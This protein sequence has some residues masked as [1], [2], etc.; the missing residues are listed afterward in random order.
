[1]PIHPLERPRPPA[2]PLAGVGVVVTRPQRQAA[3][4][5]QKLAALGATP[6]VWPAIVILPPADRAAL[7][8]AHAALADYDI[9]VFV[10]ANATEFGAPDP[11]RWPPALTVIAPGPGTA[12]ALAAV[13][14]GAARVPTTTYDSEGMLGLPE[15]Q[16]VAGKRVLVLRG[17]RGREL[18]GETL[19]RRGARVDYVAC[20]RRA[21]PQSG[22]AGLLDALR[23]GRAHALTLTSSEGL[24]NLLTATGAEGRRLL[25]RIPAFVPHPRIGERA[26]AAGLDAIVT[27]GSDAGLLGGL[28]EWFAA[29]PHE[30]KS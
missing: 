3:G 9:A 24:D 27:P 18:L 14:L 10:S 25:A 6:I 20:Y 30:T 22:A 21:A 19:E 7:E 13:G 15:L 28:L 29:H 12:E 5:A 1:M 4:L 11:A 23:E 2:G 16:H 17:D 26:R 8:R